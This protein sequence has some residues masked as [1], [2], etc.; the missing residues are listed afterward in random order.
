L[1]P[2][3]CASLIKVWYDVNTKATTQTN[4]EANVGADSFIV[5]APGK[6]AGEAFQA[7]VDEARYLH[8][9]AGYTGTI[10][11]K[12]EF[13]VIP[14]PKGE[15]PEEF[16]N[17]L[18]DEDDRRIADKWGPAGCVKVKPGEYLFFGYASS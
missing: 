2:T 3:S 5:T 13:V 10:A 6:T 4:K 8:G 9:R 11:E 15:G 16:A 18:L 14:L 12:S 7:A 1:V 17:R